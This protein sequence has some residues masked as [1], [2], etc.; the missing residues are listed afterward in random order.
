M[1]FLYTVN[2]FVPASSGMICD[3]N[4][5]ISIPSSCEMWLT[6]DAALE[7]NYGCYNNFFVNVENTGSNYIG[8]YYVGE[9]ITFSVTNLV[10]GN[11]C[12]GEAL[13][14]D[15]S[16][17]FISGCVDDTINCLQDI[18]P[19]SE[20]G[21]V[22][23]PLFTDCND[24]TVQHFDMI[25]L[26]QC[27]DIYSLQ[28]MRIWS[29]TDVLGYTTTCTQMIT[30]ER[31][32]LLSLHP[33]CPAEKVMECTP[34]S[35]ANI[36][37]SNTGYPTVVIDSTT[38][39]ITE[40]ANAVCNI[41]AS[42]SDLVIP[43]CG[44][45]FRIIRTWTVL[46]WCLPVDFSDNPWTCV[47]VIH[48]N[49]TT[50]PVFNAPANMTVSANLPGCR[51]RPVIPA[52]AVSDCSSYS[53]V[54]F[55]PSG[56]ISGNGGQVP[57]PGLNF[58]VH[59]ITV[60]VTD[61][62]GNS[63]SKTF[64]ITVNDNT[65][66]NPVC[67]QFSVV[68]LDDYGYGFAHAISFD[69]GSTDNCCIDDFEVSRMTDNCNNPANLVFDDI[70]EFCCTDV[71]VNVQVI[72]RVYDCHGNFNDCMVNVEVQDKSGPTITCPPN[73]TLVCGQD[74]TNPTLVGTVETDPTL[75]GPLDGL[76]MDNCGAN[77]VL[78][79]SDAGTIACGGGTIYRTY[80]ATDPAGTLSFCVQ[81]ITVINNNP[82]TGS[83]IVFPPD[84]TLNGCIA[85]TAPSS[86]GV[87]T[88]PPS[89]G[90]FNLVPGYT[91]LVL[92]AS[93]D[94]CQKI[95]R[96]W[97]VVDWCQYNPNNPTAGGSWQMVQTI[98][99]MDS[100][101]PV[102]AACNSQTFCNFKADCSPLAP[103]LTVSATDL[104]TPANQ[105][106]Y[107]WTV[108]LNDDGIYDPGYVTSGTGQNTT[109]NYPVGTHRISYS[110]IDGCGN[111]GFCNFI[112]AIEDCKKPTPICANGLIAEI[113]STGMVP[114]DANLFIVGSTQ[115]NCTPLSELLVSFS[116]NTADSII[117]FTCD[118]L[119][120]NSVQIWVTDEA[121]NA[122]FCATTLEVQDNMGACSS[123]LIAMA[124][125]IADEANQGVENVH[126]ELNGGITSTTSTGASGAYQF[127]NVPVGMDYTVTPTLSASPLN[128]VTTFDLLLINQHILGSVLLDSPYK[129][130]A[131]DANRSGAVTV[132]DI[133]EIRKLILHVIDDY[134]NNTS[135]RFVDGNYVFPNPANP[136]AQP[137]PEVCNLNNLVSA[138]QSVNFMAVKVGDVNGTAVG[139]NL[140]GS[141]QE[142]NSQDFSFRT[143]DRAV[144]A[145]EK[146]NVDFSTNLAGMLG[147]Q[148]TLNFDKSAL[149]FEKMAPAAATSIENFGLSRLE[150]GVVTTSWYQLAAPKNAT[151]ETQFSMTFTAL[152]DG[153]LSQMASINSSY[154]LAE[155]YEKGGTVRPV[156]LE[157]T[158]P[159]GSSVVG[160]QFEL[161]QN[162]PNPFAEETIIRFQLPEASTATVSIFNIEGKVV[163]TVNGEFSKGYHELKV[164][165]SNLPANGIF[166]YRL[167]TPGNTATKKMTLLN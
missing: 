61:A 102:F 119:G 18:R 60:K 165:R 131:A 69:N 10:T 90:C 81:T 152:K 145:G 50:A 52:V 137:F 2:P 110:A 65:K 164:D 91:D 105:I 71:G 100:N 118:E 92:G 12:W 147:Y 3:D 130:I 73:V 1:H 74:Y 15:K 150:E 7:G 159:N 55:T 35:P 134:Q 162:I 156:V 54:I 58:G 80:A 63:T 144:K 122:D 4:L 141:S 139:H 128:G 126:V 66:P 146:F 154:T 44:V 140:G 5:H 27:T 64:T 21:D 114:V 133:V 142:R 79:Q 40:G 28:I 67:D 62:C 6:P 158:S 56:P 37:P 14:E 104:C 155:S 82:F 70:V 85:S 48:Y 101:P 87:P 108:D 29:A 32:S 34:G 13:I 160:N 86:T 8:Y 46:D 115:D 77:I 103:D 149:R 161:Y 97:T 98:V 153:M 76:A 109:N 99:V 36:L 107:T 11:T 16:G 166:Y 95:L 25:T 22:L 125:K 163:K 88:Y 129:M 84:L 83:N 112:F 19:I 132:S 121:G 138:N 41:T 72:L 59:T 45:G 89:N 68:A 148:F 96:T 38:Y 106:T 49:D 51:A 135:W 127:S 124:G 116:P 143:A 157:F 20:G 57:A 47:Q 17:P 26:G 113:M 42:Y 111:I 78:T 123:P 93:P 39:E 167:Q 9:T 117:I 30:V 120:I 43:K 75:V 151:E 33:T 23:E 94:G 24:F 53:V 31:T 136:F